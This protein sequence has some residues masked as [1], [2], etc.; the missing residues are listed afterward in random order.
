MRS[1]HGLLGQRISDGDAR[2]K[3]VAHHS[4]ARSAAPVERMQWLD[5]PGPEVAL[6]DFEAAALAQ[7]EGFDR[8]VDVFQKNFHVAE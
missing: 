6:G 3:P 1:R 2:T 7:K 8:H 4:S 5:A